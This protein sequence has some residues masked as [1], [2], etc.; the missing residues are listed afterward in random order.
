MRKL[1]LLILS[2]SILAV[3]LASCKTTKTTQIWTD[4]NGNEVPVEVTN[5][6]NTTTYDF[7]VIV[8]YPDTLF[9]DTIK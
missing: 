7:G 1:T 2:I 6:G 8:L 9:T 4:Q 5:K 3:I